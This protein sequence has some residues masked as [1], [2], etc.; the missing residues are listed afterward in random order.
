MKSAERP[1]SL[2]HAAAGTYAANACV[3][4]LSLVNVLVIARMLGPVGRGEVAFLIAVSML[5]GHLLSLSLQEAN[6]NLAASDPRLRPGLAT[7]SVLFALVLGGIAAVAVAVGVHVAPAL[8]GPVPHA[9][10]VF[11]LATIPIS[12]LKQ[13]L[14]LL[15]QADY[16]FGIANAAWVAGPLT[17]ALANGALALLGVLTVETAFIAWIA[18]QLFGVC[19]MCVWIARHAG[20]GRPDAALGRVAA[21]FGLK[22]HVGRLMEVG[23]YR[24]DQWM[25]GAMVG[26][27]ELGLYSIAVAWAELLFYLPGVLVLVQRPDLVRATAADAVRRALR[28][29]RVGFLLS[30]AAAAVILVLAPLLCVGVFGERFDGSIDDLRVLSLG[31]F[32]IVAFEL[33][34]NALTAQRKPMLGSAAVGVAFVVTVVLDLLLIPRFGG[35]GAAIATT[36]A[37]TFGGIAAGLIFARA[38]DA[39]IGDMAPRLDDLQWLRRKALLLVPA[40]HRGAR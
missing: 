11:A 24:G 8:G 4:L 36:I 19:L 14:M 23:N 27:R 26:P 16:A 12:I 33:L 9:L 1:A 22:A 31:A 15:V 5:S 30:G 34:R 21:A 32:G 38:M 18:G 20:F 6:A 40:G 7:N 39:R 28:V 29:C 17:T 25:L 10:L 2:M 37:Y 13:Y 3:A 35:L